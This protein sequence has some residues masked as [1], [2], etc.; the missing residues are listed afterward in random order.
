MEDWSSEMDAIARGVLAKQEV[1]ITY[2]NIVTQKTVEVSRRLQIP[3]E[4]IQSWLTT[5]QVPNSWI[6]TVIPCHSK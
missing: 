1:L 4:E 6:D 5:K 2:S 3:E